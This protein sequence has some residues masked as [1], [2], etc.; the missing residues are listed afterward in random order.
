MW[1][2]FFLIV[3]VDCCKKLEFTLIMSERNYKQENRQQVHTE[4]K[5]S[6]KRNFTGLIV[7]DDNKNAE[8][9]EIFK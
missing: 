3:V 6:R 5:L 1:K 4:K 9:R 8:M 7:A 2:I